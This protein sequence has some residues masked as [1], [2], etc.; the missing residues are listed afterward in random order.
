MAVPRRVT[1]LVALALGTLPIGDRLAAQPVSGSPGA[2]KVRVSSIRD[3]LG[4]SVEEVIE[5]L[6]ASMPRP[7]NDAPVLSRAQA[8]T[9]ARQAAA[10][11][12]SPRIKAFLDTTHAAPDDLRLLGTLA[13]MR[14]GDGALSLMLTAEARDPGE[15][16]TQFNTAVFLQAEGYPRASK[17]LLDALAAP[18]GVRGPG[19]LDLRATLLH[20]RGMALLLMGQ[21]RQAIPL[22]REAR[23]REP[24]LVESTRGL[25]M[26]LL[27]INEEEEAR[28][29][30][31]TFGVR[32][33]SAERMRGPDFIPTPGDP[34]LPPD[35]VAYAERER[36]ARRP[37]LGERW[38]LSKGRPGRFAPM[39]TP[40]SVDALEPFR[41][42]INAHIGWLT[43]KY[44]AAADQLQPANEA[45]GKDTTEWPLPSQRALLHNDATNQWLPFRRFTNCGDAW[46]T[47][48]DTQ[49]LLQG[50]YAEADSLYAAERYDD[51]TMAAL[52]REAYRLHA[53]RCATLNTRSTGRYVTELMDRI[54][55]CP[56]A[57]PEANT[58]CVCNARRSV[59]TAQWSEANRD[60]R[61]YLAAVTR[62]FNLAHQYSTSIASNV[63]PKDAVL[64]DLLKA[65]IAA[66]EAKVRMFVHMDMAMAYTTVTDPC[67]PEEEQGPTASDEEEPD[68]LGVCDALDGGGLSANLVVYEVKVTCYDLEV[69]YGAKVFGPF[70]AVA[71][72]TYTFRG[73]D[74]G[75]LS[76]FFGGGVGTPDF[77]GLKASAKSGGYITF[78]KAPGGGQ[79]PDRLV[80]DA[81]TKQSVGG[82]YGPIAYEK[83]S[84]QSLVR[85]S[86]GS[87]VRLGGT[88]TVL[89]ST[90]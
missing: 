24:M 9:I 58:R 41:S 46:S 90:K 45:F 72:A 40:A 73:K 28:K 12:T 2:P 14:G 34:V 89:M 63:E 18:E 62:W 44:A 54:G 74:E 57:P 66:A 88:P 71:S 13:A 47:V 49:P 76:F 67:T 23:Q 80:I 39:N 26:A 29:Q 30:L 22:F 65:E 32:F 59:A 79:R 43:E 85:I 69:E 5:E 60:F 52:S 10:R 50:A 56:E 70:S 15:W 68:P 75:S 17:V 83:G 86:G 11:S 7:A 4:Q 38:S 53:A 55:R 1:I 82:N 35:I 87:A 77:G 33:A 21:P 8:L 64:R 36:T 31:R 25:A 27:M 78:Q 42:R 81:G 61:P 37:P 51:A 20:A 19:D 84:S 6:K 48:D 3:N 16:V